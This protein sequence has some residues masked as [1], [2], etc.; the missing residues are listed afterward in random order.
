MIRK[1]E[2]CNTVSERYL[3]NLLSISSKYTIVARKEEAILFS[4]KGNLP[5]PQNFNNSLKRCNCVCVKAV[6]L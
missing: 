4:I 5:L 2:R 6:S 1:E 3:Y